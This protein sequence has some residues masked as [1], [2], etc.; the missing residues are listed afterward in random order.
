MKEKDAIKISLSTYLLVIAIF[1]IIV[2]G[3]FIYK[4]NNDK[5]IEIKKSADL[6]AQV[7]NLSSTASNLQSKI[8]TISETVN[9]P[10]TS[11][12][13]SNSNSSTTKA[14]SNIDNSN[15]I[16]YEVSKKKNQ[17]GEEVIAVIKAT[18]DGKTTTKEIEMDALIADTGTMVLPT[19]GSVALVV[20]SGGEYY[21]VNIYQLVNGEIKKSGTINCGAD[22]VKDATYSVETKGETTAIITANR[23]GEIIK[24]EIEM[25]AAIAKTEV[26]DVLGYG[27][28]VLVAETGGEYYAFKVF[29]LSQDYTNGKTKGIV[30]AGTINYLF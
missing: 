14:T 20:D 25:S 30:E 7:S 11:V 16:K 22:M 18:K 9:S 21:G 17:Y 5:N 28:V 19:I 1:A 2:M 13:S 24:K 26:I 3:V 6:Q 10:S 29:R 12:Q 4:L 27:K 23:N 8:N 15:D